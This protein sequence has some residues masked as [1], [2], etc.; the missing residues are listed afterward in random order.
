[1][2]RAAVC[3]TPGGP[4]K[5]HLGKAPM[6]TL[7]PGHVIVNNKVVGVNFHDVMRR[8]NSYPGISFPTILGREGVGII[9]EVSADV[10][11]F[12]VGDRVTYTSTNHTYCDYSL[13]N[14]G[15]VQKIPDDIDFETAA[16]ATLQA[17][18][19]HYL[20]TTSHELKKGQWALVQAAAGGT[21][22]LLVQACKLLGAKVI[23]TVSSEAKFG[24]VIQA[25][26]DHVILSTTPH[27][28]FIAQVSA[29]SNG[30]VHVSYE[31]VGLAT[32]KLSLDAL[33]PRGSLVAYGQSSG[34]IPPINAGQLNGSKKFVTGSLIDHISD[35]E[36]YRWR[37]NEVWGWVRSGMKFKIYKVYDLK[38]ADRAHVDL[39]SR[40]TIGKLLLKL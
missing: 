1:M 35:P 19:V 7:V 33:R 26:A 28:K 15:L 40:K 8:K 9:S 32:W 2:Q 30:G 12:K 20:V 4:E 23:G 24:E 11:S 37:M 36:E 29:W 17:L 14:A 34:P 5:I 18:T 3:D 22:L 10:K 27:D 13:V 16:C 6:P 38:D 39:D 31:S 21:G 25:G